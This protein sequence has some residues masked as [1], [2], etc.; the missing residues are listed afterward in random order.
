[1]LYIYKWLFYKETKTRPTL[2]PPSQLQVPVSSG[3]VSALESS[4]SDE[5][6]SSAELMLTPP[7]MKK[8]PEFL[9]KLSFT[10]TKQK[11]L[12][13]FNNLTSPNS[14]W[15]VQQSLISLSVNGEPAAPKKPPSRG[16]GLYEWTERRWMCGPRP[17]QSPVCPPRR[18]TVPQ[19]H[20]KALIIRCGLHG[21]RSVHLKNM[22]TCITTFAW[23][24]A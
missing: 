18:I 21:Q 20:N 17:W 11:Q 16:D 12:H 24:C 4:I 10:H 7:S 2:L 1:M 5:E 8:S 3:S 13:H 14:F 23:I 22:T 15:I 19:H 6:L 9:Q